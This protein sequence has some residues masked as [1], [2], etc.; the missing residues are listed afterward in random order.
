M[1]PTGSQTPSE[2]T[3]LLADAPITLT[4][5]DSLVDWI[6]NARLSVWYV[7]FCFLVAIT[8]LMLVVH[9]MLW[10]DLAS[11]DHQRVQ[12]FALVDIFITVFIVIETLADFILHGCGEYWQDWWRI[13]DFAVCVVCVLSLLVDVYRWTF[14]AERNGSL[15][16]MLLIIRYGTQTVRILRLLRSASRAK[17][18]LDAVDETPVEFGCT[19]EDLNQKGFRA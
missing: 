17:A 1:A 2:Y 7:M 13:F 18:E 8:C 9:S 19:W 3:P 10:R 5:H 4:W 12:Y 11:E 16:M 14:L 15:S 6:R